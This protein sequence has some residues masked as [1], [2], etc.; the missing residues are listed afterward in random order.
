MINYDFQHSD[1]DFDYIGHSKYE[2]LDCFFSLYYYP[3][4]KYGYGHNQ[5]LTFGF[6]DGMFCE[7][8]SK[9]LSYYLLKLFGKSLKKS[10]DLEFLKTVTILPIP[11]SNSE[12]NEKRFKRLFELI[13]EKI[14]VQNGFDFIKVTEAIEQKHL[15]DSSHRVDKENFEICFDKIKKPYRIVLIDDVI[16]R[17]HTMR[18]LKKQLEREIR[19]GEKE[20]SFIIGLTLSK[21]YSC[22]LEA[23]NDDDF[24]KLD[25]FNICDY[26]E[27]MEK[28]LKR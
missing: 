26:V 13:S 4:N 2:N 21:T 1:F 24:H 5:E 10:E 19:E 20:E 25:D 14:G 9:I 22:F 15:Q 8:N 16:T 17:G 3:V 18:N 6:K 11:A 28:I 7:D 23:N 12:R 27:N